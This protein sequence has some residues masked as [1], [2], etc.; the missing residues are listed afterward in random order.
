MPDA[1]IEAMGRVAEA[2]SELE[3][4][5]VARVL[6]WAGER[7]GVEI[8]PPRR[9]G[10]KVDDF[11]ENDFDDDDENGDDDNGSTQGSGT[12]QQFEH[13]AELYDAADPSNDQERVL[14][15]AYWMQVNLEKSPFGSTELNR[16]LKDLGHGITAINKAMLSNM[17]KKPALV[18]QVSRGGSTRQAR[19]KY[20]VTDAGLKW[21]KTR[22]A[23]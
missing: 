11:N 3:E 20:K 14:V 1:E 22:L 4:E 18:L 8:A 10:G 6:R 12:P 23:A 15:A 7:Y 16:L 5:A 21:M 9:R 17:K 13:F 2:L 19:K